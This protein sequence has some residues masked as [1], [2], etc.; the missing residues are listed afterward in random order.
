MFNGGFAVAQNYFDTATEAA[1][2]TSPG[3]GDKVVLTGLVDIPTTITD[4]SGT[5]KSLTMTTNPT[6][7]FIPTSSQRLPQ[8]ASLT[9]S[10]AF[11]ISNT[12]L[13][14]VALNVGH[15]SLTINSSHTTTITGKINVGE[16]GA[17][18]PVGTLPAPVRSSDLIINGPSATGRKRG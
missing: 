5:I 14:G 9:E 16:E 6:Y 18:K 13:Y 11:T 4:V 17:A 8:Y 10:G 2:S 12:D 1:P 3:L 15:G 7:P